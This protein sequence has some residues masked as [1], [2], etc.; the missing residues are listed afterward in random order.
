M[1]KTTPWWHFKSEQHFQSQRGTTRECGIENLASW[2]LKSSPPFP[3]KPGS[4]RGPSTTTQLH[5]PADKTLAEDQSPP[6]CD[7]WESS[8]KVRGWILG[9]QILFQVLL[10]SHNWVWHVHHRTRYDSGMLQE[11][12][13]KMILLWSFSGQVYLPME[14]NNLETNSES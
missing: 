1:F 7:W 6:C 8:Y 3:L 10:H 12:L 13:L 14:A 2:R 5:P 11:A 4:L 9:A